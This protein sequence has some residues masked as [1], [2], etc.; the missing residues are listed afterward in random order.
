M[1]SQGTMREWDDMDKRDQ[2][3]PR[4]ETGGMSHGIP[5]QW[6]VPGHPT[7]KSD[8]PLCISLLVLCVP[9][10]FAKVSLLHLKLAFLASL[11]A[12]DSN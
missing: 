9:V 8:N 7:A 6:D 2:G 10:L 1:R 12:K 5:G 4:P 3:Y 11:Q